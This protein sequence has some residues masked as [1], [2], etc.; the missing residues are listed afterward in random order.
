MSAGPRLAPSGPAGRPTGHDPAEIF[1]GVRT[2]RFTYAATQQGPW[3]LYD[4]ER[5]PYQLTNRVDDPAYQAELKRLHGLTQNWLRAWE[6]P[7]RPRS[8]DQKPR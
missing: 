1:R 2:A 8:P 3:L 4:L 7:Y 5:D 6:D